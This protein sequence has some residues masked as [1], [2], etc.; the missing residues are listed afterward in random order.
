MSPSTQGRALVTQ[1]ILTALKSTQN[2]HTAINLTIKRNTENAYSYYKYIRQKIFRDDGFRNP[3]YVQRVRD[4]QHAHFSPYDDEW[5]LVE[6]LC[7][8]PLSYQYRVETSR[9]PYLANSPQL[10]KTLKQ[11]RSIIDPFYDYIM[12][13]EIVEAAIEKE[14]DARE[15]KHMKALNIG[16]IQTII[17]KAR[18]WRT[19]KE[20]P[21]QLVACA[22]ILTGR[23]VIEII[24]T[25]EWEM[26]GD[27]LVNV[28]GI[29]KQ[30]VGD[31]PVLI[32]L[33]CHYDDFNE[34]MQ[35]IRVGQL[36]TTANTYGLKMAFKSYFGRWYN[37]SERRNIYGEA[38]FRA[39]NENQ[40]YPTMSKVMWIDKALAHNTNVVM[41]AGNLTYQSIVF[42][43]DH[44]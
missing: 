10:D 41:Q 19:C 6:E 40:F 43:D 42:T 27:Y 33:L 38:A 20:N 36:P 37:H 4:F 21:W 34:L 17:S 3:N 22:L 29:A 32:P 8:S 44:H 24:D 14:R 7:N 9:K 39:R 1:N 2:V 26:A 18:E 23:R 28:R 13:P 30:D 25:L 5:I 16:D 15:A 31:N 35:Q 12:P 11:I